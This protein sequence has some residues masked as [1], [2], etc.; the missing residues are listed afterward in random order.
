MKGNTGRFL[1]LDLSEGSIVPLDPPFDC[2]RKFI[3]G[4][5]LAAKL[6]SEYGN[7]EADPLAPDSLLI[8][9]LGPFA[10]L[11]LSGASRFSVAARSPLTG[12][13]ADSSCGGNF[14]PELRYAGFD[15][16]LDFRNGPYSLRACYNGQSSHD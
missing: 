14:A 9:A 12:H 10:G 4:A 8:F 16:M 13:W 5:G 1:R 6:F 3:G 7:L 15:G 11:R 2:Y